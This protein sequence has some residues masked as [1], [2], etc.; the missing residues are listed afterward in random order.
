MA[1]LCTC[2]LRI[3][4][5]AQEGGAGAFGSLGSSL[6]LGVREKGPKGARRPPARDLDHHEL[7]CAEPTAL[8]A[9]HSRDTIGVW[10]A[11]A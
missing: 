8:E 1:M 7:G 10:R 3:D 2:E 11:G 9:V 5:R 6:E 4:V